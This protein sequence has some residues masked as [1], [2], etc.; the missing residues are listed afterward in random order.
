M[1]Y[2]EQISGIAHE[3]ALSFQTDHGNR[4]VFATKKS[5]RENKVFIDWSQN[6]AA[7]T[8]VAMG[9]TG[10]PRKSGWSS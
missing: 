6:S 9:R 1:T 10:C 3:L 4:I 8:T 7:K 5:L 2:L